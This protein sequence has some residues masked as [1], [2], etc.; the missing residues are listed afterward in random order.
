M[1]SHHLRSLGQI[2]M[3]WLPQP[4]PC[5][6]RPESRG[7]PS[8]ASPLCPAQS[9]FCCLP[10]VPEGMMVHWARK[11]RWPGFWAVYGR[12]R[13]CLSC[14]GR[15]AP[16]SGFPTAPPSCPALGLELELGLAP[17]CHL[18]KWR[19]PALSLTVLF[20]PRDPSLL[21]APVKE[22]NTSLFKIFYQVKD[23]FSSREEFS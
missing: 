9:T 15:Q 22:K 18:N 3:V 12:L 7:G 17:A 14:R 13:L 1:T 20:S 16:H 2:G 4:R 23:C 21:S 11:P 8:L 5:Q 19:T 6:G 10:P